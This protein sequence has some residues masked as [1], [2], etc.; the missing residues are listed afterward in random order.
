[1]ST[2]PRIPFPLLLTTLLVACAPSISVQVLQPALVSLPSDVKTLAVVDRSKSAN[3]GQ[4]I[5]STLEGAVTGEAIGADREG[6][7]KALEEFTMTVNNGPRF[8][9]VQPVLTKEQSDTSMWDDELGWGKVRKICEASH[10][11][12]IVSLEAFDSDTSLDI[13][14]TVDSEGKPNFTVSRNSSVMSAWRVYYP[15]TKV[16]VDDLRDRK[17]T[18][19]WEQV[20]VTKDAAIAALPTDINSISI[21]GGVA[22]DA[23]A[24]RISPN[25]LWVQRGYYGKGSDGLKAGKNHVKAQDWDGAKVIWDKIVDK[26]DDPKIKGRAE[27][28]LAL[29]YEVN[30]DLDTALDW[31]KKG[32]VDL[33]NGKSRSYV[34][35]LSQRLADE[36]LLQEQMKVEDA[37]TTAPTTP[38]AV[39]AQPSRAQDGSVRDTTK[40]AGSTGTTGDTHTRPQ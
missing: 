24:R 12:A 25:Y 11:D 30:G 6:A 36:K 22:G 32:A 39:P 23:Y 7:K 21:V 31:A 4:T 19:S 40:P 20:G 10:A 13:R 17:Y 16:V 18:Q 2:M 3:V 37:K 5:L 27:F 38:A 29:Y 26:Q 9:V 34:S 35:I 28:D 1:M 14:P 15:K 8:K 33:H